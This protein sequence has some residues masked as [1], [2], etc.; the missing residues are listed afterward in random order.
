MPISGPNSERKLEPHGH[1]LKI[2]QRHRA[3]FISQLSVSHM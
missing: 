3:D 1:V 2:P